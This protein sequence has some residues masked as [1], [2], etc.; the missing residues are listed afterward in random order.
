M[1]ERQGEVGAIALTIEVSRYRGIE[2]YKSDMRKPIRCKG[3]LRHSWTRRKLLTAW[4]NSASVRCPEPDCGH[5][6]TV[7]EIDAF[8]KKIDVLQLADP[9]AP[10]EADQSDE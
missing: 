5:E 10:I 7:E 6:L 2:V 3:C 9:D 8:L 1:V 4:E